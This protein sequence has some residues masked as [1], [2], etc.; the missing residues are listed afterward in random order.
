MHEEH[1][2]LEA[3]TP[4]VHGGGGCAVERAP[5]CRLAFVPDPVSARV[6]PVEV[7]GVVGAPPRRR[8]HPR[9][10]WRHTATTLADIIEL[11]EERSTNSHELCGVALLRGLETSVECGEALLRGRDTSVE[12]LAQVLE[13]DENVLDRGR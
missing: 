11:L 4:V 12:L 6:A 7:V 3:E 10:R 1:D 5:P 9:R 8:G 13:L 2:L